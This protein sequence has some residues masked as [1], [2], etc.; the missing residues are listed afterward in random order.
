MTQTTG[1]LRTADAADPVK[2]SAVL[3]GGR[4][5]TTAALFTEWARVL[6]FPRHFGRNWDGFADSLTETVFL[7][8]DVEPEREDRPPTTILLEDA[9]DLLTAEADLQWL[10]FLGAL[11]D[12]ATV[13][14][15]D[16]D[17]PWYRAG[18][19]RLVLVLQD[20]PERLGPVLDRLGTLGY[21]PSR[22]EP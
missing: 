4:C 16:E 2:A 20:T 8:P 7:H 3:Q 21:S 19:P 9:G 1:W 10:A 22:A 15:D 17:A 6:R 12:A 14:P 5:R 13:R 11:G 18:G